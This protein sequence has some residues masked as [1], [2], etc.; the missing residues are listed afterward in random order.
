MKRCVIVLALAQSLGTAWASSTTIDTRYYPPDPDA[1]DATT[2]PRVTPRL[3]SGSPF[4]VARRALLKAGWQPVNLKRHWVAD[5]PTDC[6]LLECALH[7]QGIVELEG[8][9]TD[10]PVCVF[11]YRKQNAWLQVMATGEA[12]SDLRVYFW[13]HQAPEGQASTGC[14]PALNDFLERRE[15][16][17]HLRG[18]IP[19]PDD[20]EGLQAA[21]AAINQH[22]QGTDEALRRMKA[23]CASD[24]DAMAKLNTLAPRIERKTPH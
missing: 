17:D 18:E 19:D 24:P 11:Y 1:V 14:Q 10:K 15:T 4:L 7:R 5:E 3:H 6:G 9:P 13:A 22:C 8:C 21:I 2:L 16:C 12:M 20:A 23:R